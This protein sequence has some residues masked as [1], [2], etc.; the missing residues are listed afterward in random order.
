MSGNDRPWRVVGFLLL[1]LGFGF[2]LDTDWQALA[3]LLLLA[4][5]AVTGLGFWLLW[6]RDAR[7]ADAFVREAGKR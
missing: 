2:R 3:S 6:R 1:V 5:A 4:G 7:P